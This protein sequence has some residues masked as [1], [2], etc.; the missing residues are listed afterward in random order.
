MNVEEQRETLEF[1]CYV[2]R[3]K[4]IYGRLNKV[5]SVDSKRLELPIFLHL[6]PC[7]FTFTYIYI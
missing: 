1:D 2:E 6:L 3:M 7:T 5:K 4:G